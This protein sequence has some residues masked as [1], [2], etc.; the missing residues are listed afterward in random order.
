MEKQ[1][2]GD[3]CARDTKEAVRSG[4]NPGQGERRITIDTG[5]HRMPAPRW[6]STG[7]TKTQRRRLQKMRRAELVEKREEDTCGKWFN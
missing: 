4:L 5:R 3:R 2:R 6:C 1:T 7:L